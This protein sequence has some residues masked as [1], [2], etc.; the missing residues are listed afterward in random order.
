MAYPLFVLD[1]SLTAFQSGFCG[2]I[3]HYFHES[4][5]LLCISQEPFGEGQQ[6]NMNSQVTVGNH[7]AL[8][9]Y[10]C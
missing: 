2:G 4:E 10:E 9:T 3:R 6:I 7:D 1:Y 5:F 8:Y